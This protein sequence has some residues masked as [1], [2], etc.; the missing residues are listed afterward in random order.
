M[1]GKG[2]KPRVQWSSAYAENFNNIFKVKKYNKKNNRSK[3]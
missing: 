1:N 3:N 2:D